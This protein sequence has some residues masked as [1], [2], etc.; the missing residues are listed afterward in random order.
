MVLNLT[1]K[2]AQQTV[3]NFTHTTWVSGQHLKS[4][5]HVMMCF[6]L[7]GPPRT[8]ISFPEKAAHGVLIMIGTLAGPMYILTQIENYKKRD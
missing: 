5:L 6:P 1:R 8:R 2:I 3:R 4:L 7:S